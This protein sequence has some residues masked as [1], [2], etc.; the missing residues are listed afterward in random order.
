VTRAVTIVGSSVAIDEPWGK[1]FGPPDLLEARV[2]ELV[3]Q[4]FAL[5]DSGRLWQVAASQ[6][7]AEQTA[8]AFQRSQIIRHAAKTRAAIELLRSWREGDEAEQRSTL[9]FL[10][11]ALDGNRIPG[12]K[13]FKPG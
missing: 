7:L 2:F 11:T 1:R 13:L 9:E 3:D 6:T 10:R 8:A 5:S 4:N 12:I